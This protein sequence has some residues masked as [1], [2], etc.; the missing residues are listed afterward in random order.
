LEALAC[1]VPVL[2]TPVGIAPLALAGVPNCLVADFD[3]GEWGAHASALLGEPDP[4]APG[5]TDVAA[6]FSAERM[7]ARVLA[8]YGGLIP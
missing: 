4:R 5:G 8:A 6:G 7:A 1:E 2:S 3:A